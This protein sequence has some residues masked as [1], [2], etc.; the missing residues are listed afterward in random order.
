MPLCD[1]S[2]CDLPTRDQ[3]AGNIADARI[4][5]LVADHAGAGRRAAAS[6][7]H[8]PVRAHHDFLRLREGIQVK[9]IDS[10]AR[11]LGRK[12]A[13]AEA[14]DDEEGE[15]LRILL[16]GTRHRRTRFRLRTRY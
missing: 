10:G 4:G 8:E 14:V 15:A 12:R 2:P 5:N 7:R 3:R 16:A 9:C 6:L 11:R 1:T 13:V